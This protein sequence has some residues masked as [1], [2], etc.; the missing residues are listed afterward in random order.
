MVL[1]L[2]FSSDVDIEAQFSINQSRAD[3]ITMREDY[4]SLPMTIHDDG[5]GDIGFDDGTDFIR[6]AG[7]DVSILLE[8]NN[9]N[10]CVL[11]ICVYE[12]DMNRFLSL[13]L[14]Q[15]NLMNDDLGAGDMDHTLKEPMPG[16]SRS[17]MD[18]DTHQ[19]V[20]DGFGGNGFGREYSSFTN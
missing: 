13:A 17:M 14:L 19:L 9:N 20:D 11:D 2:F 7:V 15:D 5:F 4:G 16:T 18:I 10:C 12:G 8:M 1:L 3:E 6:D